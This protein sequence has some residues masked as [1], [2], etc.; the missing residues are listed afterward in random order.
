MTTKYSNDAARS[1]ELATL[2]TVAAEERHSDL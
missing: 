2:P 1:N